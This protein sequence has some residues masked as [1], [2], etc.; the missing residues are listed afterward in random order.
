MMMGEQG[1]MDATPPYENDIYIGT[2]LLERNRHSTRLPSL[3]VSDWVERFTEAGFD[4]VELWENHAVLASDEER[5]RLRNAP[6][7]MV[8]FNS[9]AGCADEE[10][11]DR[12]RAA[13]MVALFGSRGMKFNVGH[14]RARHETYIKNAQAWRERFPES[15]RMLCECHGKTTMEEPAVAAEVFQ[16]MRPGRME[17]IIHAFANDHEWAK[18]WMGQ[19]GPYTTHAHLNVAEARAE[20]G[21]GFI[22]ERL[23]I[24]KDLGFRGS[25]TIEFTSGMKDP[26]RTIDDWFASAVADLRYLRER[27]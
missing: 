21:E 5:R 27:L 23:R 2:V 15:F 6:I 17:A 20:R 18:D 14:E 7:P 25:Y 16:R 10:L 26:K 3:R 9:Y 11:S 12:D 24:L 13:R 8:I 4:G 19:L 22:A 1:A